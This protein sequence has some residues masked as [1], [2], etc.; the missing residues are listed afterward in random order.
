MTDLTYFKEDIKWWLKPF[1]VLRAPFKKIIWMD[2]DCEVRGDIGPLF[3]YCRVEHIGLLDRGT[4]T[5]EATCTND[6]F[7]R[8]TPHRYD[9]GFLAVGRG[10]PLIPDWAANCIRSPKG[11]HRG[12]DEAMMFLLERGHYGVLNLP[13]TLYCNRHHNQHS[14]A[15]VFHRVGEV[16]KVDIRNDLSERGWK[17]TDPDTRC[18]WRNA[19]TAPRGVIVGVCKKQEHWLG[20]WWKQY[21]RDNLEP[22]AF[23]DMGMSMVA[24]QW[25]QDHGQVLELP[26]NIPPG[27]FRKPFAC[28]AS[29]F[30]TTIWTDLDTEVRKNLSPLYEMAVTGN[31]VCHRDHSHALAHQRQHPDLIAWSSGTLVFKHSDPLIQQWAEQTLIANRE[32][33]SDQEI[34]SILLSNQ[35]IVP[36]ELPLSMVRTVQECDGP[37]AMIMH[38]GGPG[39][40]NAIDR[41][42]T[43]VEMGTA[44]DLLERYAW[45]W[46]LDTPTLERGVVVGLDANQEWLVPWFL[47]N[48][49][50]FNDLPV[51]FADFGMT[52]KG[53]SDC[54]A[55]GEVVDCRTDDATGWFAKP[56]ALLATPFRR[57]VW[58]D[59]D[60]EVRGSLG[61]L[62]DSTP[63][64]TIGL[65]FDRG[66][67]QFYR[68][69]MPHDALIYNS[70]VI[71]YDHKEPAIPSWATMTTAI[72]SNKPG[73]NSTG[74]PGDQETLALTLKQLAKGRIHEFPA[75]VLRLRMEGDGPAVVMHWT[76]PNG[77]D[78]IR[79]QMAIPSSEP[80]MRND[81]PVGWFEERDA[82]VYMA[83]IDRAPA[84]IVVEV[85]TWVGRSAS[86][87]GPICAKKNSTLVCVDTFAGCSDMTDILAGLKGRS[88]YGTF[89]A[90]MLV[91]Q[92]KPIVLPT[93]SV[94]AATLFADRSLSV[95]FIDACH[96]YE[97]V[98]S[99]VAAWL[100]KVRPG[101]VIGGHDWNRVGVKRAVR[102]LL[103]EPKTE[104]DVWYCDR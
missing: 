34:L 28:L 16:G 61:P 13:E 89:C 83:M 74:Q 52:D 4:G 9:V 79:Q 75:E 1:A 55:Q 36:I 40:H 42:K 33:R 14:K 54:A 58:L 80:W 18:Q 73:D 95:V 2:N 86:W 88:I 90:N 87:A 6:W 53:R 63:P 91:M 65:T 94:A 62:I 7:A 103:G 15:T 23:I 50:R 11:F 10:N 45:T 49:R 35:K 47:G 92:L 26:Q 31:V 68:D 96:E 46:R 24:K 3:D 20:W 99:D 72:R 21:R 17:F 82:A 98:R 70:G 77:K 60:C 39:G 44:R 71:I 100:P 56:L 22:V 97:D 8:P 29:P 76:G 51:L 41:G 101:G 38:F 19:I 43:A 93:T 12:D 48:L 69:C 102:E 32:Q 30:E 67:P 104:N 5:L 64:N 25:C 81:H 78:C 37:D 84:G 57:T 27:W 85:G 59:L 66:T